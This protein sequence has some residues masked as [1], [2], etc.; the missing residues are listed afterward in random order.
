V[1]EEVRRGGSV[2]LNAGDQP[3]AAIADRP[4]VRR[5]EPVL[6]YFSVMPGNAVIDRHKRSGGI[7]YEASGGQ[8]IET[9]AGL[10]RLIMNIADLPGAFDGRALSTDRGGKATSPV[11]RAGLAVKDIRRR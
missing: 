2:V 10:Q 9:A 6:R 1:A 4:A 8:L 11:H 5:N 3:T 7:C